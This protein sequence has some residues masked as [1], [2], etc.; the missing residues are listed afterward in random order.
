MSG[1]PA[2]NYTFYFG[3]DLVKNGKINLGQAFYDLVEVTINP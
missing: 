2:G 1:L 3:V